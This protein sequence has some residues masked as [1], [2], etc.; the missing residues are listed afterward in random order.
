MSPR[1]T[2]STAALAALLSLACDSREPVDILLPAAPADL[3]P[4]RGS[5]VAAYEV[6]SHFYEPLVALDR[7]MRPGPALAV[8]W[9]NP[10]ALTWVFRL[11]R[12]VRFHDG[13]EFS[14]ADVIWSFERLLADPALDARVHLAGVSDVSAPSP[15]EVVLRTAWPMPLLASRLH[16][17]LIAR[18][19]AAPADLRRRP[20]GT[21]PFVARAPWTPD[22]PLPV[23]RHAAYWGERPALRAATLHFSVPPA[24]IAADLPGGRFAL[25]RSGAPEVAAAARATGRFAEV[26]NANIFLRHIGFGFGPPGH[27]LDDRRVREAIDLAL[28]RAAVAAAVSPTAEPAGQLVPAAI[29]GHDPERG[30]PRPDR[31]RA[32]A[33]LA[34]AGHGGGLDLVLH[35]PNG[36][37]RAA[38]AVS[39]Q[40]AE[41]GIR[42]RVEP[43]PSPEFFARLRRGELRFWLVATG[44]TTGDALELLE[45]AFH[46]R[47]PGQGLG[48][49]NHGRFEDR[50]LD[51]DIEAA[52]V[53]FDSQPRG[54]A[55]RPLLARVLEA[56]VWIPLYHDDSL[57]LVDRRFRYQ[58]RADDYFRATDLE[59]AG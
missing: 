17:V 8:S 45:A 9:H 26:G 18:R 11:R 16:F 4:H 28:D 56:R 47:N 53:L 46:S 44:A 27:P 31:A 51:R 48:L 23:E 3:D 32:R 5:S 52:R 1:L 7:R 42:V 58:P 29:L 24:K 2:F 30:V 22:A 39:A 20:N 41:V 35:R 54:E 15:D 19:G 38:A 13:G 50:G 10:D 55:L 12:K 6:A 49:E 34:E 57:T 33:L 59:P 14:A 43:L 37:S 40:L 25:L 36:Y 21:G